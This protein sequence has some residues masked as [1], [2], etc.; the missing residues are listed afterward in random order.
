[1]GF[2][3]LV[4]PEDFRK[5]QHLLRP[6]LQ[7]MIAAFRGKAKVRICRQEL[8][9]DSEALP[10]GRRGSGESSSLRIR[11]SHKPWG[12]KGKR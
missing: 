3:V 11:L 1:M 6:I 8:R 4:I 9:Q 12:G 5:D 2:R 10:R 7:Q